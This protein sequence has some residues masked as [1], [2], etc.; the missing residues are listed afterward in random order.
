MIVN[1]LPQYVEEHRLPLIRKAVIG[2]R[3]AK[4]FN[5]QTGVKGATALNLLSTN[6]IFGNGFDCGWDDSGESTLSQRVLTPGAVKINMSFCDKTLLKTWMNYDVRVAAGQKNLPAEEDFM[7]GVIDSVKA[8]LEKAMWQGDTASNQANLNK[9]DGIIK[10][11]DA[12]TPAGTY[13]IQSGDNK[14]KI[15][16]EVYA[17]IPSAAYEKGEVVAYVGYDFYRPWVQELIANGNLVLNAGNG[18]VLDA[19]AMPTSMLIPGTNVRVIPVAGLDGTNRVFASY[20][21][22]FVYGVDMQGDDEKAEMWY[23]QDNREY[24]LAIEFIAGVQVAYPDMVA[25]AK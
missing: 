11:M 6:V 18:A 23:S 2:N 13:T 24:R 15:L 1:N 21:D 19:V 5:L 12:E 10:I 14:T 3:T 22:N 9:F 17:L 25:M 16:N 4:E 20:R 8:Q 7:N